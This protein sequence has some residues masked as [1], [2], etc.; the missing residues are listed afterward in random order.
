PVAQDAQLVGVAPSE[1]VAAAVVDSVAVVLLVAPARVLDLSGASDGAGFASELFVRIAAGD[2]EAAPKFVLEPL[3]VR[4]IPLDEEPSH[5][6]SGVQAR[7]LRGLPRPYVEVHQ[8]CAEMLAVHPFRDVLVLRVGHQ[9]RKAESVQ[10]PLGGAFPVALLVAQLEELA[11]ER[12]VFLVDAEGR[13]QRFANTYL[14]RVDV[15]PAPL[16][17]V[18]LLGQ[19]R[20]LFASLAEREVLLALAVVQIGDPFTQVLGTSSDT[21]TLCEEARFIGRRRLVDAGEQLGK[22]AG[23]LLAQGLL[24]L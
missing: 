5:Q 10:Q 4:R 16:Q 11:R 3:V 22:A 6:G 18:D 7:A 15:A 14:R 24:P 2:V 12:Q 9:Q 19:G 13:A 8:A 21:S 1:H 23:L 20:M 17:T